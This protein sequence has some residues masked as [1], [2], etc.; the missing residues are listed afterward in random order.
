MEEIER[1]YNNVFQAVP[2]YMDGLEIWVG[3]DIFETL[4]TKE[5]KG[6]KIYTDEFVPNGRV[7]IGK[8][9]FNN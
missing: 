5:Y 8:L 2:D 9:Y 1:V 6:L 7:V 4:E 3:K